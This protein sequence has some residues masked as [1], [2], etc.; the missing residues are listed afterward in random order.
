MANDDGDEDGFGGLLAHSLTRSNCSL[1]LCFCSSNP[2]DYP[3]CMQLILD[4][5]ASF[6][7]YTNA[8]QLVL[9]WRVRV[10]AR[11][12]I[13]DRTEPISICLSAIGHASAGAFCS[14]PQLQVILAIGV[15]EICAQNHT[16]PNAML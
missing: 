6:G 14:V 5:N 4:R 16:M 10:Q 3:S 13:R 15:R 7:F 11:H 2:F 1:H 12:H 8:R 9:V